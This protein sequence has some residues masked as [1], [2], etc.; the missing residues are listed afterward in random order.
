LE[1]NTDSGESPPNNLIYNNVFYNVEG[2]D[3]RFMGSCSDCTN[4][5]IAN[6]IA[7]KGVG[8]VTGS[9]WTSPKSLTLTAASI[10]SGYAGT[11]IKN[12][13]W[14]QQTTGVDDNTITLI[15]IGADTNNYT[16]ATAITNQSTYFTNTNLAITPAFIDQDNNDFHLKSTSGMIGAGTSITDSTWGTIGETDIGAFKYYLIS[17]SGSTPS[18][19]TGIK[20]TGGS[21]K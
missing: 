5:T 2:A 20:I 19:V 17:G 11:I 21:Y 3:I 9:G 14:L 18:P 7:Y 16:V 6:N 10:P 8:Y 12:N 15:G 1:I 13:S 4:I